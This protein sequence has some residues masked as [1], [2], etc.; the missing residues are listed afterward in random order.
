MNTPPHPRAQT[1]GSLLPIPA[2]MLGRAIRVL[3][4]LRVDTLGWLL[5]LPP[6]SALL[7]RKLFKPLNDML[8][9]DDLV[10]TQMWQACYTEVPRD[11]ERP[12]QP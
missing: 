6:V 1:R 3:K 4:H 5:R 2:A 11:L 10:T 12:A 9:T 7:E 8:V